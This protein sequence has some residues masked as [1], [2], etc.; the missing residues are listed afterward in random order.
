[1]MN[2]VCGKAFCKHAKGATIIMPLIT[3]NQPN[4][5][6]SNYQEILNAI[7]DLDMT[8]KKNMS[9]QLPKELELTFMRYAFK[10]ASYLSNTM[11]DLS[12]IHI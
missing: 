9:G 1:M 10:P 2:I 8:Y 7:L 3:N 5:A 12:L 11:M 6:T 4:D